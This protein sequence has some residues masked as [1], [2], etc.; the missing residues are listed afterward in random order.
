MHNI[1][2]IIKR[3]I[4]ALLTHFFPLVIAI[5]LCM[6]PPLYAWF[7]I[8]SNWDP[9]GNSSNVKIAVA[10][11]DVGWTDDETGESYNAGDDVIDSLKENNSIDWVMLD[12]SEKAVDGVKSGAYYAAVVLSDDFS[13]NM[14][15]GFMDGL[16]QP[17]ITYYE[18]EKKNAVAAKITDT[19]VSTLKNSIDQ[20]YVEIVVSTLFEDADKVE[21]RVTGSDTESGSDSDTPK[22]IN[23]FSDRIDDVNENI[24][25]YKLL[26]TSLTSANERLNTSLQDSDA[27]LDS[28]Q[29]KAGSA[30]DTLSDKT[31]SGVLDN[32]NKIASNVDSD[33]S[34]L[35]DAL[36][37][38]QNAADSSEKQAAY[39]MV[40][41]NLRNIRSKLNSMIDSLSKLKPHTH[42]LQNKVNRVI[43]KLQS[44]VSDINKILDLMDDLSGDIDSG[45]SSLD[46]TL[47]QKINRL[48]DSYNNT[49]L[50]AVEDAVDTIDGALQDGSTALGS[51]SEDIAVMRQIVSGTRQSVTDLNG[52]M[53]NT[54]QSL[55]DI[56]K[57]L[58]DLK[59]ELNGLTERELLQKILDFMHGDPE[60]YGKFLAEP[61][62]IES[63]AIYP[64][65]NYGSGVA[66]FYTTLALWVGC[67][68]LLAL[69]K[70]TPS[71]EG[72][73]DP[74]PYQLF[75]GRF[76]I[77]FLLGQ[78]Q[79]IVIYIG[80]IY[81]LKTQCLHPGRMFL[82][83]A[84]TS[85]TFMLL[86]YAVT[87]AFADLGK[88]IIVV[89][90]VLQIAG[91][92]GTYPIEVLP[93]FF[94]KV[95]VFFPFPYAI[96]A[97]RECMFGYYENDYIIYMLQLLAFAAAAL[98]LGLVIRMPFINVKNFMQQRMKD[99]G[100]M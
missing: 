76:G 88:A 3:D 49:I 2:T 78:L 87:L 92:S 97:M 43:T 52:V 96:N 63:E 5:G 77:L 75:F 91:S 44:Q 7:N 6:L 35:Q 80:N 100:M 21:E 30:S 90:V 46:R 60:G 29:Q 1:L 19:A 17:T 79:W 71:T 66:P 8:Y 28:L 89:I 16:K 69:M 39:A 82:T 83:G 59:N 55:D 36:D 37:R 65:E 84:V 13:R 64:V 26:L 4:K 70:I 67:I 10:S 20:M 86:C 12:S 85:F 94:Q 9:Y 25:A 81:V 68:F 53:S 40:E 14:Y 72:L 56:S 62:G 50:P 51:I 58:D 48:H 74:R 41:K 54:S 93:E 18:N 33:L 27:D 42:L 73:K 15:H 45:L 61:V 32:M 98:L 95:Y 57:D 38:V 47:Q 22:L 34:D 23:T 31:V 99:T 11:E 24:K